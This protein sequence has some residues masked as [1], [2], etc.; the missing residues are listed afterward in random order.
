[1]VKS[2]IQNQDVYTLLILFGT[3]YAFVKWRYHN[4]NEMTGFIK[5]LYMENNIYIAGPMT[6]K[7]E[8]NFPAFFRAEE[9]LKQS[10]WNVFNPARNDQNMG[11]DVAGTTGDPAEIPNFCLRKALSWDMQRICESEAIY[12]LKGWE[13]SSGARAEHTLANALKLQVIYE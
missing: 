1:M 2:A 6:G 3:L 7:P 10:G 8:F 13:H 5:E 12:M 11:I 9:R 4:H